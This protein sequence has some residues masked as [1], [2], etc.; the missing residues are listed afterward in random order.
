M[1]KALGVK[2]LFL[3]SPAFNC[4]EA[5][6]KNFYLYADL[7]TVL[8]SYSV[9]FKLLVIND[10][11]TDSTG[12][13]L[14]ELAG[15]CQFLEVRHNPE[16]RKNA[17]NIQAGYEWA[18]AEAGTDDLIGCSDADGE[19]NPLLFRRHIE[20]IVREGF[21][22][23][24]GSIIYP[25][26]GMNWLDGHMM[27]FFGGMQAKLMGADD[28]FY[29]QSP[30]WQLHRPEF[31]R[32]AMENYLPRYRDFFAGRNADEEFP[33]WGFHAIIDH[34]VSLAG[35][36]LHSAYLECYGEAPNRDADKLRAQAWA[37]MI[38]MKTLDAF[39]SLLSAGKVR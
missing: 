27:R 23:I 12:P 13:I 32:T 3:F 2:T 22:G 21:D 39:S 25:M 24:V 20:Y 15:Q 31:L 29:I 10:K 30:G 38:H 9:A 7:E 11:S 33:P 17:A 16:N 19:H 34:L 37:A 28:L 8:A 35:A 1:K 36:K 6:R 4:G 5:V 14:D 26:H 18:L